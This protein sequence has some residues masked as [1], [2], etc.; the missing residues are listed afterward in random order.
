MSDKGNISIIIVSIITFV[1]GMWLLSEGLKYSNTFD[2][3]DGVCTISGVEYTKDIY[4]TQN[5]VTCDCGRDCNN[6]E[7][8][9]VIISGKFTSD[10]GEINMSGNFGENVNKEIKT[11]TF[12]EEKCKEVS[13][14]YALEEYFQKAKPYIDVKN[15]NET[16]DCYYNDGVIYIHNDYN[17]DIIIICS[18]AF[19]IFCLCCICITY[20]VKED[21]NSCDSRIA[22]V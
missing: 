19:G 3:V 21:N 17:V 11:C 9:C 14:S 15:K 6:N 2:S 5:M 7:G 1:M 16:I 13:R 8:M 22:T 20:K 10:S 12:Q 4:D 18:V